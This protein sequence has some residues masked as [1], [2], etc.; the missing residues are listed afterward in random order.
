MYNDPT[1]KIHVGIELRLSK[2]MGKSHQLLSL[3]VAKRDG[4]WIHSQEC[5]L[6]KGPIILKPYMYMLGQHPG[7]EWLSNLLFFKAG[8]MKR[9][10]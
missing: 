6:R 4:I 7:S 2:N 3:G 9:T 1:K 8:L 5:I 10:L